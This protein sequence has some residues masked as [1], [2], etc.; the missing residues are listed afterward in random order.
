[1]NAAPIILASGSSSRSAMLQAA[2]VTFMAVPSEV[3]EDR[4]R[5]LLSQ[6]GANGGAIAD[7]LAEAKAL[8]VSKAYPAALVIGSDQILICGG[9]IFAKAADER[10]ARE[11]LLTLRGRTHELISAVAIVRAGKVLWRHTETAELQMR[12]FSDAFLDE[13]LSRELP[14]VLGSVG[15][16]RIEGRGAQLFARVTG[17]QFCI[18]G[19]P[20]VP[21]LEALRE[22]GALL[23]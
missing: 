5:Q 12:R 15:C 4:I 6:D 16:Y 13:Y 9:R 14:D 8:A 17:D 22:N 3:D 19:M 1:V 10:E 21:L 20:L 18:R 11:T 23:P 7:A 2:D